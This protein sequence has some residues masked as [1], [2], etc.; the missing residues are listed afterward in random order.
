[1]NLGRYEEAEKDFAPA[2]PQPNFELRSSHSRQLLINVLSRRSETAARQYQSRNP[3]DYRSYYFLAAAQDGLHRA[4][5][6]GESTALAQAL[7]LKPDYAPAKV[8]F[9][10]ISTVMATLRKRPTTGRRREQAPRLR[11]GACRTG[12]SLSPVGPQR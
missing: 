2:W 6:Q 1:M 12:N 4:D 5:I 3:A 8:L 7:S 10:R 11:A 9:A